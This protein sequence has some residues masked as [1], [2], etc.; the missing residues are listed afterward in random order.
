MIAFFIIISY[1]P[2]SFSIVFNN[3]ILVNF[4]YV[5]FLSLS[6]SLWSEESSLRLMTSAIWLYLKTLM[7]HDMAH[8]KCNKARIS[9]SPCDCF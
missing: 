6:I 5:F 1:V 8:E 4:V 2:Y 9:C 7:L 3:L